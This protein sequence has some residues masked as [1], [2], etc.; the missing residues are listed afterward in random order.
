MEIH[1]SRPVDYR[2]HILM[3]NETATVHIMSIIEY[4]IYGTSECSY[5]SAR[6]PTHF[7]WKLSWVT[8]LGYIWIT[9]E[10]SW[11]VSGYIANHRGVAEEFLNLLTGMIY[12]DVP[13]SVP[14]MFHKFHPVRCQACSWR[15]R[16]KIDTGLRY[17]L[18]SYQFTDISVFLGT[19]L[20]CTINTT[21][22]CRNFGPIP[23]TGPN[24]WHWS[25]VMLSCMVSNVA[26][27]KLNY[28]P[29]KLAR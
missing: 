10:H 19:E 18:F 26:V 1:Y 21:T 5:L 29:M 3:M 14:Y 4:D 12:Q 15:S 27:E 25:G 7:G 16:M 13:V 8:C 24:H 11:N 9:C 20:W 6:S 23:N 28:L 22:P 2:W 17:S